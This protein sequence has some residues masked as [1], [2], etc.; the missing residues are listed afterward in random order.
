VG[1]D[2]DALKKDADRLLA[3]LKPATGP[4]VPPPSNG[5][6]SGSLDI[7]KMTPEEIRKNRSKLLPN[8]RS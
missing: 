4:G 7:S 8:R 6:Q 1:T 2:E 3:H 5:G